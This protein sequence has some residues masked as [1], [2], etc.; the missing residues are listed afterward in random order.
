MNEINSDDQEVIDEMLTKLPKDIKDIKRAFRI[1][2]EYEGTFITAVA[3]HDDDDYNRFVEIPCD[4]GQPL[5][6][7]V[8]NVVRDCYELRAFDLYEIGFIGISYKMYLDE[9]SWNASIPLPLSVI[10]RYMSESQRSNF[11]TWRAQYKTN[12]TIQLVQLNSVY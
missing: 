8:Y 1:E 6:N 7:A 4:V 9:S 12:Y 3:I 11:E 2:Q 10:K 5:H